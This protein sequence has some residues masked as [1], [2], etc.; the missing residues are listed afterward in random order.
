MRLFEINLNE[1]EAANKVLKDFDTSENSM[2]DIEEFVAGIAKWLEEAKA[3]QINAH[4]A[5]PDTLKY[6]H[7]F[8]EVKECILTFRIFFL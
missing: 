4:L 3:S 7:D 1:D 5:G 8:Y 2:V 6:I